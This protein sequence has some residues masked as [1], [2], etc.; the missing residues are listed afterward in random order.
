[1]EGGVGHTVIYDFYQKY[2][3]YI[4]RKTYT[5]DTR[6][7]KAIICDLDGTIASMHSRGPFE[8]DKVGQDSPREFI[9]EMVENYAD[10]GYH[11]IFLSGRDGIC[12]EDT[13]KWLVNN[14]MYYHENE[15]LK[16]FMRAPGDSRKDA[17]IKEELFWEHVAPFYNV[18]AAIDDRP[19]MVRLYYEL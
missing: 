2:L 15:R 5:P 17:V 10:Q 8:W 12:R 11:I 4:G 19:C 1:R 3:Q 16:L 14:V 18:V 13:V 9:L 6:L 7:P